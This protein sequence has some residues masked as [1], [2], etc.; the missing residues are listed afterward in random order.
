MTDVFPRS[1]PDVL[2][3]WR[4]HHIDPPGDELYH[5]E[6]GMI[7]EL[8]DRNRVKSQRWGR[9]Q[10]QLPH[11]LLSIEIFNPFGLAINID[12]SGNISNIG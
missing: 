11:M 7:H 1:V 2:F 5:S 6:I 3:C 12:W 8:I 4:I 10:T 9:L